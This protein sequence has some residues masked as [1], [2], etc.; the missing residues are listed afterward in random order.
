MKD[1]LTR[2][3]LAAI[4]ITTA[5]PSDA[6]VN[7][8]ETGRFTIG[9][10]FIT[11][12]PTGEFADTTGTS[13][14]FS[15]VGYLNL[16]RFFRIRVDGGYVQYGSETRRVCMPNCRVVFDL[17]TSNGI[18]FGS[19]GPELVAPAG[20]I[21]PYVNAGIG[22]SYFITGSHLEGADDEHAIGKTTNFADGTFAVMAGGGVYIPLS[23]KSSP[24]AI[25]LGL[26]YHRNGTV[27]YLREGDIRDNADGTIFFIPRQTRADL[28]TVMIGMTVGISR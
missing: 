5:T 17:K 6:Q 8:P 11:G 2:T 23:L 7:Q 27:K 3:A 20:R 19:A 14:G 4:L 21:R 12:L 25:D 28:F 13:L 9:G 16:T 1:A 15:L 24:V 10:N 18:G 22:G 26:R